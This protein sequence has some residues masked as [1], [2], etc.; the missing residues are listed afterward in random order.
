MF[1]IM[2]HP[3]PETF[4][5]INKH[6][7]LIRTWFEQVRVFNSCIVTPAST[8]ILSSMMLIHLQTKQPIRRFHCETSGATIWVHM[9]SHQFTSGAQM[10]HFFSLPIVF[11]NEKPSWQYKLVHTS[12]IWS[13]NFKLLQI[14]GA[15]H[16][17]KMWWTNVDL[18]F[19]LK[20]PWCT[21][22]YKTY[23]LHWL[24]TVW[25]RMTKSVS[26]FGQSH[27][28]HKKLC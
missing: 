8:S 24:L 27:Q 3:E 9:N 1:H 16:S 23:D 18:L 26:Y 13:S 5:Y 6:P 20:I 21:C 2:R 19:L 14:G 25:G 12:Q 17:W 11:G 22:L 7:M 15:L 4:D 10:R 28:H